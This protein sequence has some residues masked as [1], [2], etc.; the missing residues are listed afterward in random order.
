MKQKVFCPY[1]GRCLGECVAND[2]SGKVSVL[3]NAPKDTSKKHL[4]H[5]MKCVKCKEQ[6]YILLEFKN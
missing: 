3:K 1:C 4:I 2:E 6:V 5:D